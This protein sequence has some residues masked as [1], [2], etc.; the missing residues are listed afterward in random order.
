MSHSQDMAVFP[1]F[2]SQL[3]S[4][5]FKP[6]KTYCHVI[7]KHSLFDAFILWFVTPFI[8]SFTNS[9]LHLLKLT[10]FN[11]SECGWLR[12]TATGT[13]QVKPLKCWPLTTVN[14]TTGVHA[15]ST[16]CSAW[17]ISAPTVLLISRQLDSCLLVCP[18]VNIERFKAVKNKGR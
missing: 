16:Y 1:S 14:L 8:H 4:V 15:H 10:Q 12:N 3:I 9:Q 11:Y 7:I 18:G 2:F 17:C 13:N 5:S 6:N